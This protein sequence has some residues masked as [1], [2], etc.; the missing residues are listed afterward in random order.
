MKKMFSNLKMTPKL[1]LAFI[2]VVVI[3]SISGITGGIVMKNT[4]TKYSKALVEN[5]FTQGDV[6]RY[7]SYLYKATA[8]TRD[9]ILETD[10]QQI[11]D[12]QAELAEL[13]Q[14]IND[15]AKAVEKNCTTPKEQELLKKVNDL[16]PA[17]REKR[18]QVI[19]LGLQNKNEEAFELFHGEARPILNEIM[20]NMEELSDLNV[21]MGDEVSVTLTKSSNVSIIIIVVLIVVSVIVSL[22]F[23]YMFAK[24]ITRR[25]QTVEEASEKMAEGNLDIKLT[26]DSADEIGAMQDSLGDAVIMLKQYI[27]DIERVLG[28]MANGNFDVAPGVQYK[29]NFVQME[30]SIRRI[31]T[32]MTDTLSG[33]QTASEQVSSGA[34]QVSSGA[35]ALSQGATEQASSIE[36][37]AA[38]I[39]EISNHIQETANQA[40]TAQDENEVT[41]NELQG[42]S[43]QM[44]QMVVAMEAINDKSQEISKII[45]TIE[46]IAFQTNIL[47][48]NAAVEAARAGEA[49]KGFAVVADEV[50]NLAAKS[51]EAANSTTALIGETVQ[52]VE[53]GSQLSVATETSLSKVVES[54]QKSMEAISY[55]SKMATE[56]AENIAQVTVGVDQISSVVQTN[57]A[58]AEESAAA[59]EELSGQSNMLLDLVSHFKFQSQESLLAGQMAAASKKPAAQ[60]SYQAPKSGYKAPETSY[61]SAMGDKY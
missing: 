32:S 50:R 2:L 14:Q 52:A 5:G 55:I 1:I 56:Q 58:T 57:S 23:A 21:D 30:E 45:K 59:S 51:A 26:S 6:G 54:E 12:S 53:E 13:Q 60:T 48:L 19:E 8:V 38:S 46:D 49:G 31:V 28:E 41:H 40:K 36:E 22:V 10:E 4:D 16:L 43:Q 35:Q 29:G 3:S 18:D 44:Q 61:T 15:A 24:S 7:M 33:I 42:C 47:A 9:L 20:K 34:D 39:N 11:K 37:L 25:L 27:E 17:Y